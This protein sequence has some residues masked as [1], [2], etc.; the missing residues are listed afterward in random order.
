ML[1]SALYHREREQSSGYEIERERAEVVVLPQ[2]VPWIPERSA[3]N[4]LKRR[5]GS[6]STSH[7]LTL[8]QRE[9]SLIKPRQS[10]NGISGFS[11]D[12][13]CDWRGLIDQRILPLIGI[14]A[15]ISNLQGGSA[16]RLV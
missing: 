14:A 9:D 5:E 1:K 13:F 6:G 16:S 12:L 3:N 11:T 8:V 7:S 10:Q 2:T 4:K 15:K